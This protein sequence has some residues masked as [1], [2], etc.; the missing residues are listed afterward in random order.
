MSII[1]PLTLFELDLYNKSHVSDVEHADF[2][3]ARR[4]KILQWLMNINAV[5][6]IKESKQFQEFVSYSPLLM[7][8]V[9]EITAT[10]KQYASRKELKRPIN[11]L[12]LAP[13]GSGKST[14]VK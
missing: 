11:V 4:E 14:L 3:R 2:I 6:P 13:P 1:S 5:P 9:R 12:L 7:K 10:L 8:E